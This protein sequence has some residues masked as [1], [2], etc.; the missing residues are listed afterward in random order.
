MEIT[1][2]MYEYALQRIEELL[3][4]TPDCAPEDDPRAAELDMVSGIVE[5]YEN[6]HYPIAL[7]TVGEIIVDAMEEMKMSGKEL[8][9]CIGVSQNCISDYIT[10]RAE[11]PQEIARLLCQ[12]LKIHP[13]E[14][15]ALT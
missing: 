10:G 7:P 12:V 8:A 3:P 9:Q 4:V 6:I 14:F 15:Q 13:A 5:E 11:P 2:A 1:K